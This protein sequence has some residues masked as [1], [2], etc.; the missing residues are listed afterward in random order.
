MIGLPG[1]GKTFIAQRLC[2][3]LN[4]KGVR[5]R[6]FSA[7]K[8]G[9]GKAVQSLVRFLEDT[10]GA[11]GVLGATRCCVEDRQQLVQQVAKVASQ[12]RVV[13]IDAASNDPELIRVNV[14]GAVELEKEEEE[15]LMQAHA[16]REARQ[17]RRH[18]TL[19]EATDGEL[20]W[21]QIATTMNHNEGAKVSINK[22][23]GHLCQKL[24]FFLFNLHPTNTTTYVRGRNG[25][26]KKK[27]TIEQIPGTDW[28]MFASNCEQ[29]W[30]R[31]RVDEQGNVARHP[32][33]CCVRNSLQKI[34]TIQP[35]DGL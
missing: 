19:T 27:S 20:S 7:D 3:W 11:V 4:W 15:R 30:R 28:R 25:G 16:E 31:F 23:T 26:L 24:L 6:I 32:P 12:E 33:P 8:G 34:K 2:R 1:R 14:C 22:V 10:P 17:L 29:S 5:A 18:Q 21:V 9:D 35:I 13:F